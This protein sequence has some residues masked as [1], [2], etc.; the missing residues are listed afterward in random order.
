M[1]LRKW[2]IGFESEKIGEVENF[3][4]DISL[5]LFEAQPG[6]LGVFFTRAGNEYTTLSLW[7]SLES[8]T[9]LESTEQYQQAVVWIQ[10]SSFLQNDFRIKMHQVYGGFVDEQLSELVVQH[11]MDWETDDSSSR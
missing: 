8:A 7:E 3:S 5:P 11:T 2:T 1:I 10:E 4:R 6:C 9:S